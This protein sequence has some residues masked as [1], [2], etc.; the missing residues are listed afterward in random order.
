[1]SVTGSRRYE[2]TWGWLGAPDIPMRRSWETLLLD[3]RDADEGQMSLFDIPG[4]MP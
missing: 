4:V 2:H 3:I 1:M